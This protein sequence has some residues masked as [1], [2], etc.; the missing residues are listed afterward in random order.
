MQYAFLYNF[1][2]KKSLQY[3]QY[4]KNISYFHSFLHFLF[5]TNAQCRKIANFLIYYLS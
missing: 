4:F 5:P 2:K 1:Y 3:L